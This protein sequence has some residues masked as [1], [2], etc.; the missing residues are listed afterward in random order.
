MSCIIQVNVDDGFV[1]DSPYLHV[2]D[3]LE[4]VYHQM[5]E[6][7]LTDA[8]KAIEY[9]QCDKKE[10]MLPNGKKLVELDFILD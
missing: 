8:M 5:Q 1:S 2:F 3:D 7:E 6:D 4:R 9:C 10:E